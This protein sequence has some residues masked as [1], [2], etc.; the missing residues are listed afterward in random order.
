VAILMRTIA[1]LPAIVAFVIAGVL[2]IG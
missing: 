1:D 2:L